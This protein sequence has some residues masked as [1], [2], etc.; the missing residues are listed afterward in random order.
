MGPGEFEWRQSSGSLDVA[1][2]VYAVN[3]V[4]STAF[5]GSHALWDLGVATL[6]WAFILCMERVLLQMTH[7]SWRS[8]DE[9]KP[10][11][12]WALPVF[13]TVL[14]EH[15]LIY[16]LF[17]ALC[18]QMAG[19]TSYDIIVRLASRAWNTYCLALYQKCLL[20]SSLG[21]VWALG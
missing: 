18:P 17:M 20:T 14:W 21:P 16:A 19:L 7:L 9:V 4:R 3:S 6:S 1:D 5:H 8:A 2:R 13:G 12:M 11:Q 15:S 10:G